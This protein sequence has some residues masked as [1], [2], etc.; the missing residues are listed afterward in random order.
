MIE[1]VLDDTGVEIIGDEVEF[2]AVTIPGLNV[3]AF[4]AGN[5]PA[6][7]GN[8]QTAFPILFHVFG[9]R[10]DL[11]IHQYRERYPRFLWVAGV[12]CHFQHGDLLRLVH[13]VRCQADAFVFLHRFDHVV[14][15]FLH[16]R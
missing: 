9:Q 14:D 15:K 3:N 4:I 16:G 8:A 12:I 1:L 13:L 11:G 6:Q 2:V 7:I 10:R 5:Q